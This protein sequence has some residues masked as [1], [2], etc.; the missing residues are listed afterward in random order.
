MIIEKQGND[1]DSEAIVSARNAVLDL[2]E[3]DSGDQYL[4]LTFDTESQQRMVWTALAE[5][6]KTYREIMLYRQ[7]GS[8]DPVI[9]VYNLWQVHLDQPNSDGTVML[10]SPLLRRNFDKDFADFIKD[11]VM[12]SFEEDAVEN[13]NV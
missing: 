11:I 13:E 7:P 10:L 9:R 1:L 6:S 5:M 8:P 2:I 12:P 4:T 3:G